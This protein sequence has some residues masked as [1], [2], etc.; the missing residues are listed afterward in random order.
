M[1]QSYSSP[2]TGYRTLIPGT[3]ITAMFADGGSLSGNGGCNDYSGGFTAYDT[4]LRVSNVS[5]TGALC[6]QPEG[7]DQQESVY[8]SL[9][10]QAARFQVTA[11]QLSIF[12][13][14]GNRILTYA[15]G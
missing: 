1:L 2:E 13:S 15:V 5:A 14:A 8:L 7:V 12:D 4:T 6:N 3:Q 10:R 9:L 11:G